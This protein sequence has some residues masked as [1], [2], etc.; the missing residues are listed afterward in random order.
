[1]RTLFLQ[2]ESFND[3]VKSCNNCMSWK[4]LVLK[5][6]LVLNLVLNLAPKDP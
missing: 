5:L 6:I 1:M 4:D 2:N 3:F